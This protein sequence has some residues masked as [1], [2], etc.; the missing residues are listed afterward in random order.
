MMEALEVLMFFVSEFPE[1]TFVILGHSLGGAIASRLVKEIK[2]NKICE[3]FR[4]RICGLFV[5]DIVEG[6]SMKALPYMRKLIIS[7]PKYFTSLER[8]IRYMITSKTVNNIK[9]AKLSMPHLLQQTGMKYYWKTNL[10]FTEIYWKDWFKNL[11]QNFLN[12]FVPKVLLLASPDRLDKDLTIAH[13]SGQFRMLC[14]K[15]PVG[16]HV[17]E[18]DPKGTAA[19][20]K[21]FLESFKVPLNTNELE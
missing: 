3:N 20:M 2:D 9:S 17:H 19:F 6:T 18:D 16:H 4:N 10:L 8:A 1:S 21:N 14:C 7:R 13:M 11:T 15:M 12:S 5:I